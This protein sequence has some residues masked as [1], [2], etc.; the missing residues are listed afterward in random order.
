MTAAITAWQCIGCGRLEASAP[1][2]GVCQDRR[3]ELVPASELDA[4]RAQTRAAEGA[5]ELARRLAL[6]TPRDERWADAY[7][8]FQREARRLIADLAAK[9]G[10]PA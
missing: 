9:P 3:V 5:L 1:C 10:N 2:I 7:R 4:A 8:A 6:T